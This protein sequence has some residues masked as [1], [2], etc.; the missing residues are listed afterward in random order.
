[1]TIAFIAL[2]AN[3]TAWQ[4]GKALSPQQT[5]SSALAAV[6]DMPDCYVLA[7]SGAYS[8]PPIGPGR[9]RPYV[10]A[11]AAIETGH[12]LETFMTIL[13]DVEARFHRQRKRAWQAR[14]LDLDLLDFGA[15]IA[16]DRRA[17]RMAA[18]RPWP[19]RLALR[20]SFL[21]TALRPTVPHMRLHSRSFV[22][23]PLV[24][25]CPNWVHPVLQTTALSLLRGVGR[26][27]I[28]RLGPII[29]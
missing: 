27:A 6:D 21:K 24:E 1:M 20:S 7:A 2:G 16:P 12:D 17:W 3:K 29:L 15:E 13:H 14:S 28:R 4:H 22:I 9:Q 10:N 26:G 5:V 8:T 11:V 19:N 18:E 25:L 23:W